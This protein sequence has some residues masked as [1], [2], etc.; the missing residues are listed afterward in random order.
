M[1]WWFFFAATVYVLSTGPVIRLEQVGYLPPGIEK[2]LY[3]P[4][5]AIAPEHTS[6]G[7]LV[8]WYIFKLWRVQMPPVK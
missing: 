5:W 7:A 2:V 3:A 6:Q 1:V 8:E 4:L